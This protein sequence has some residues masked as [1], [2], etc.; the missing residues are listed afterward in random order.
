[1]YINIKTRIMAVYIANGYRSICNDDHFLNFCILGDQHN[2]IK[3][4]ILKL[5]PELRIQSRKLEE[6]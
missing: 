4:V 2:L 5:N 3:P 1:M 6:L